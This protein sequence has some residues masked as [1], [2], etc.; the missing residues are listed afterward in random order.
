MNKFSMETINN[1]IVYFNSAEDKKKAIYLQN[2]ACLDCGVNDINCVRDN[3]DLTG[4]IIKTPKHEMY[5][6]ET[7]EKCLNETHDKIKYINWKIQIYER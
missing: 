1:E 5:W 2:W 4:R 6:G 7:I 3:R